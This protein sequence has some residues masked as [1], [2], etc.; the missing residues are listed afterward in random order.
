MKGKKLIVGLLLAALVSAMAVPVSAEEEVDL[1]DKKVAISMHFRTDDYGVICSEAFEQTM[2]DA[3][4]PEENI[5]VTD[6]NS[7][8][9]QQ[10]NDI[11]SMI[12]SGYDAIAVSP[13]DDQ[14]VKDVINKAMDQGI[15][16]VTITY[17]PDAKVTSNIAAGNYDL[18]A[19]VCEKLCEAMDY[20][21]K[22]ALLDITTNLWRTN[23]RLMAFQ[24]TIAQYPDMEIVDTQLAISPDEAK[25]VA[26]NIL[27]A[28]PDLG[29]IFGT[30]SNVQ[31]G[32]AQAAKDA[33]RDDLV[34]GGV[35]ADTSILQ[36]MRDGYVTACAAQ[37]PDTHG[38]MA[39]E[40]ILHYLRGEEV[41]PEYTAKWKVFVAGEE[42][43]ASEEVWGKPLE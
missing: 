26:E 11:E 43:Q 6:S 31:Y 8:A 32:A 1:S 15:A 23:Q 5:L 36:L 30:F 39:A 22:V 25:T 28:N 9:A 41:E 16:V 2:L 20:K 24:D 17:V 40:A 35:D 29:G 38:I 4:I 12:A 13:V 34:I 42:E 37:F 19:A 10:L 21:G 27:Q 7:D 14:A 3:G 18:S 33:G